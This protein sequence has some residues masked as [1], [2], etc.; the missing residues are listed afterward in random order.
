MVQVCSVCYE[1]TKD[2]HHG[3]VKENQPPPKKRRVNS[4]NIADTHDNN[5]DDD[6]LFPSDVT[7]MLCR[8]KFTIGSF[9][10]L[11]TQGPPSG[12]LPYFPFLAELPRPDEMPESEEDRQKRVRACQTCTTD[13]MNQWTQFQRDSLPIEELS[14]IH[15]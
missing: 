4:C 15:I 12:G 2:K 9:K 13:L 14:L 3:F 1:N 7:C 11:H 10:F 5:D 8:R 6:K